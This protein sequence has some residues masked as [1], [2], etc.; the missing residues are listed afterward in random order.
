MVFI[1]T[2]SFVGSG[3]PKFLEQ[4]SNEVT[5]ICHYA[6]E[7][8]DNLTRYL[9]GLKER[10]ENAAR[11]KNSAIRFSHTSTKEGGTVTVS[12]NVMGYSDY[13]RFSYIKV[14]GHLYTAPDNMSIRRIEYI[15][16]GGEK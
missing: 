11:Q 7:D 5:D 8:E 15:K 4:V 2:N 16:E 14:L 6:F 10:V 1:V 9:T 12:R 13:I 3:C